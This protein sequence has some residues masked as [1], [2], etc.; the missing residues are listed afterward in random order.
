MHEINHLYSFMKFYALLITIIGG[1]SFYPSLEATTKSETVETN[2]AIN[3]IQKLSKG[4]VNLTKDT[5]ISEHCSDQKRKAIKEQLAFIHK[6]QFHKGDVFTV[7]TQKDEGN[8]SAVLIRSENSLMPLSTRVYALALIQNNGSW[9]PAPLPGSFTNTGY[10]YDEKVEQTVRKLEHWMALEKTTREAQLRSDAKD[11]LMAAII[12]EEKKFQLDSITP[13]QALLNFFKQCSAK[14]LQGVLACLDASSVEHQKTLEETVNI[15]SFG[16]TTHETTNEWMLLTNPS[17]IL[18]ILNTNQKNSEI[19]V[20]FWNPLA[21]KRE[22]ILYFPFHQ[23]KGKTS[24]SLP[25]TLKIALLPE[26]E[27]RR[28]GWQQRHKESAQLEAQLPAMILKNN[29]PHE[30]TNDVQRLIDIFLDSLKKQSFSQC[31]SLTPRQGKYFENKKNQYSILTNLSNLWRTQHQLQSSPLGNVNVIDSDQVAL[32]PLQYPKLNRPGEFQT[33]KVW[34]IRE[35]NGWHLI[36]GESLNDY[37]DKKTKDQMEKLELRMRSM[38]K[39]LHELHAQTLLKKVITVT[40]PLKL[41]AI[42]NDVAKQTLTDFRSSLRS[43]D[44]PKALEVCAV[45]NGTNNSQTLKTLNYA[46]RGAADQSDNDQILRINKA[47]QWCGISLRTKSKSSGAFEYPLYIIINTAKGPKI[48]L[49]IDLRHATNK[50]RKL[51][52]ARNWGKLKSTL[53]E[54]SLAHLHTLFDEHTKQ[55]IADIKNNETSKD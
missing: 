41:D 48:L 4:I 9:G 40:P 27:R 23:N 42:S 45:L 39:N 25:H 37:A 3:Y 50:G 26:Q 19:A 52:N 15:V 22:H 47:E 43:N 16:L 1:L 54:E 13:Q 34:F 44:S 31:L 10:G 6:T 20:G 53:P 36:P 24:I 32:L 51:L 29:P 11:I 12:E 7:A 17:V 35:S 30:T 46:I 55:A 28:L 33:I 8:F 14:N 2:S 18:K 21:H 38:E 5:A 49:D